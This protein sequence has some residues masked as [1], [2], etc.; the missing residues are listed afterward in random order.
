[1]ADV[2]NAT[3]QGIHSSGPIEGWGAF[4]ESRIQAGDHGETL[5]ATVRQEHEARGVGKGKSLAAP[6]ADEAPAGGSAPSLPT[7]GATP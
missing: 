6:P 2:L 7:P 3:Q 5:I 4:V 1:M